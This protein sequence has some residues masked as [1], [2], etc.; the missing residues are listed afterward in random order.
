MH[1]LIWNILTFLL[2]LLTYK[3]A[4]VLGVPSQLAGAYFQAPLSSLNVSNYLTGKFQ[5]KFEKISTQN[6]Y[7]HDWSVQAHNEWDYRVWN[8][9][10][11]Y[12]AVMGENGYLFEQSYIDNLYGKH[13]LE[14]E[15]YLNGQKEMIILVDSLLKSRSK[16]LVFLMMPSKSFLY[17]E[18]IP[19]YQENYVPSSH[20][21]DLFLEFAESKDLL[22]LNFLDYF[23][24]VKLPYPSFTKQ[25]IHLSEYAESIVLDSLLS[26]LEA[27]IE[28]DLFDY[29]FTNLRTQKNPRGRDADIGQALN[30]FSSIPFSEEL[31]YR[32][33]NLIR[34]DSVN[35]PDVLVIGDSFYWGFYST[36]KNFFLFGNHEF[37]Y[38]NHEM[39]SKEIKTRTLSNP[40]RCLASLD[41]FDYIFIMVTNTSIEEAGWGYFKNIAGQ[42]SGANLE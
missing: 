5:R 37:W 7:K 39:F 33:F 21:H 2:V 40:E 9:L 19:D 1:K 14:K 10:N 20:T 28:V 25:G 12:D 27:E 38:R 8:H 26:F 41:K 32:D 42:V 11:V 18:Q 30:L 6:F 24:K 35:I 3:S 4:M 29:K 17:P 13:F 31:A 15:E 22:V 16:Q 34:R 36:I 23:Q